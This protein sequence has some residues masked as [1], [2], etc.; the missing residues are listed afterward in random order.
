MNRIN[1]KTA[2]LG[3][4]LAAIMAMPA[5]VKAIPAWARKYD[6]DCSMCH[7]GA[8]NKLTKFGRDF[9]MRGL[10]TADDEGIKDVAAVKYADYTSGRTRFSYTAD[11]DADPNTGFQYQALQFFIGG[12]LYDKFSVFWSWNLHTTP[13]FSQGYLEYGSNH[14][15]DK[16]YSLR[17]GRIGPIAGHGNTFVGRPSTLTGNVGDGNAWSP[18][19]KSDG[20][21]AILRTGPGTFFEAGYVNGVPV[22][23][24][25][26]NSRDLWASFEQWFDNEG[27]GISIYGYTGKVTITSPAW[28]QKFSR[29]GV[30]AQFNRENYTLGA[31]WMTGTNDLR[32]GGNRHPKGFYV[33]GAYNLNPMWTGYA[34]YEDFDADLASSPRVQS[35]TVGAS[36]RLHQLGRLSFDVTFRKPKGGSQT[37]TFSIALDFNF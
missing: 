6:M 3:M 4:S 18:N 11:K 29:M 36:N 30:N 5:A 19:T 15:S 14:E 34:R 9:L 20:L 28:T 26:N 23:N 25:N 22:G 33:E 12:P 8:T 37:T 27:S 10:R 2:L 16:Y 17:A 24:D 35:Y 32:L 21:A 7:F 31:A 13:G 1:N